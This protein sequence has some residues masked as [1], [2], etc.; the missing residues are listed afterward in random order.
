M[1]SSF[2]FAAWPWGNRCRTRF[3]LAG[4]HLGGGVADRQ[5]AA[6]PVGFDVV[7]DQDG[8]AVLIAGQAVQRQAEDVLGPAPGV[9][10]DLG[11]GPDL[12]RLK[13]VQVSAQD[14]HDLRRQVTARFAALRVGG[15][16]GASD[17]DVTGQPGRGLAGPGQAQGADPGQYR[18]HIPA[19]HVPAVAADPAICL[20][21]GDPV[22]EALHVAAAQRGR[23][24]SLIWP[25]VQVLRQQPHI[26]DLRLDP[27]GAAAAVAGQLPG[28]PPLGGGRQPRLGDL[29][30]RQGAG[31]AEDR[32]VP[33][34]L[35]LLDAGVGQRPADIAGEGAQH[36]PGTLARSQTG[37]ALLDRDGLLAA[38]GVADRP[39]HHI[40]EP[41]PAPQAG[42]Q[43]GQ[44]LHD[45][46]QRQRPQVHLP[47]FG[48][49]RLGGLPPLLIHPGVAPLGH[50]PPL[51]VGIA[52][53][54]GTV[55]RA[56]ARQHQARPKWRQGTYPPVGEELLQGNR[57]PPVAEL[58]GMRFAH[59]CLP[60]RRLA[61][62]SRHCTV[63]G[64]RGRC[65]QPPGGGDAGGAHP[66]PLQPG[67]A[68]VAHAGTVV[69]D[70][71]GASF[72][73]AHLAAQQPMLR[74]QEQ[75]PRRRIPPGLFQQCAVEHPGQAGGCAVQDDP[76]QHMRELAGCPG[77]RGRLGQCRGGH[78]LPPSCS[79]G[80]GTASTAARS[81]EEPGCTYT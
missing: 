39:Q 50:A 47:R 3:L 7:I 40:G 66:Q 35:A 55:G 70:G 62:A 54:D 44:H 33:D 12:G 48:H 21:V 67:E 57:R 53:A 36:R 77:G 56:R 16:V 14:R 68:P 30:E 41:Q 20:Q 58:R 17:G 10:P 18:P 28:R 60:R 2:S 34:V 46:Q 81:R 49:P 32:Q 78:R 45:D 38:E 59:H 13:G 80:L 42:L 61:L 69:V 8:T 43:A 9:D 6:Q 75:D 29:G 11:G 25:A 22:E 1:G 76:V 79:R 24:A 51:V 72:G 73:P 5:A 23:V 71:S 19:D 37:I 52:V 27:G 31:V 26:V 63:P 64:G 74:G 15:D 65:R 4:D